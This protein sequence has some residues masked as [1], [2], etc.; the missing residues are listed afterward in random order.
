[1]A[2]TATSPS[3]LLPPLVFAALLGWVLFLRWPSLDVPLW[4]VDESIHAAVARLLGDGGVLYHDATD[5][6]APLTYWLFAGLFSI[7]GDNNLFA[8][9]LVLA[10]A[11]ATTA[12]VLFLLARRT[13]GTV[14]GF[15]AAGI[16]TALSTNLIPAPDAFAA[17][18]EWA[19]IAFT[20]AGA[21]WFWRS[22]AAPGFRSGLIGGALFAL[23]FLSKQPA[24]L[25]FGAPLAATVWLAASGLWNWRAATRMMGGLLAG[26]ASIVALV[27][28]YFVHAGALSEALFYSWTYN[29]SFYGPE[30]TAADRV[31]SGFQPFVS[32]AH[33]YPLVLAAGLVAAVLLP[34]RLV[35]FHP[36]PEQKDARAWYCYLL[37]WSAASLAG[38]ASSGRG[39]GHY[40]IQCLPIFSLAAALVL[41]ELT[42]WAAEIHAG[43]IP[44][45]LTV[46]AALVFAATCLL[47]KPLGTRSTPQ[48]PVDPAAEAS[49]F[50]RE[51][52]TD[53]DSLFVW[54]FNSDIHLYTGRKPASRFVHCTFLTGLIPW[55]NSAPGIDTSY[56]IVP[57]TMDLLLADLERNRPP[58]VIDCS[59]GPH[60]GF[61]KYPIASFPRLQALL[62]R[63]YA[64]TEPER[65][66]P[67]GFRL[68]LLRN[69]ARRTPL[70]LAGGPA[71]ANPTRPQLFGRSAVEARPTAFTVACDAPEG[72]IQRLELLVDGTVVDGVSVAPCHG[73]SAALLAPF[74]RLPAGPHRLVARATRADG[75]VTVSD[76]L[77]VDTTDNTLPADQLATFRIPAITQTIAPLSVRAPF[78]PTARREGESSVYAVHAPSSMIFAL[79][80]D[81]RRV[82]GGFGIRPGAFA[83]DNASP[84]DG[85]RFRIL[86]H[87]ADGSRTV[88]FERTLHPRDFEA[89]RPAQRFELALPSHAA[90]TRLEFTTDPGPANNAACD[91]TFW[92]DLAIDCID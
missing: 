60:R 19:V 51:R 54:G 45:R 82:R 83:P 62:D 92:S 11:I 75:S 24:I 77:A 88:L 6:R 49:A 29:L 68:H 10:I 81:V 40:S 35:Q 14:A 26:F 47:W 44:G 8:V 71:V 57:G 28:L 55:T 43:R 5:I 52:T 85:A 27:A 73:L 36:T 63:D 46:G 84:T 17:H 90:D 78:G 56:A 89:D 21:W 61:H 41:G 16:F 59:P 31:L 64:V 48:P 33:A 87:A 1:M 79:P 38:A 30:I 34:I 7:F 65:F 76:E 67:Q 3:R 91:W 39:F 32:L 22:A 18:T 9:R 4:N 74:D 37:V 13:R 53:A 23:A 69:H 2:R 72:R 42:T 86:L 50:I 25:D 20:T 15:W 80:P 12:F 70:P 58:F 66:V